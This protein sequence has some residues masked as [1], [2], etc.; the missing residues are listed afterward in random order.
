MGKLRVALV[1]DLIASYG[2]SEQVLFELH[3]MFPEARVYTSILDLSRLPPRFAELQVQTS[4]LQ[5]VPLL[6]RYYAAIVPFMPMAFESFDLR[7]FDLV[8]S[9]THAC[10]KGVRVPQGALHTCYCHTPIRYVWSHRQEYLDTLPLMPVTSPIARLALDRLRRWDFMAAQ[11]VDHFIANS[12]NVQARI[13]KYYNRQSEVVYPPVDLER[14]GRGGTEGIAEG[15]YLV[16]GRL[17][18]YKRIDVAVEAFTRLG[19]PLQVIGR[20]PELSRL[21]RI[22]GPTVTFLGEVD[23]RVLESAYRSCRA[24]IFTAD[25]DFGLVPLEAMASGRPVLALNA[26]GAPE[27]VITGVT[28]ELYE[29]SGVEALVGAIERFRPDDYDPS[30]CRRRAE[31]FS[32]D[33]FRCGIKTILERELGRPLV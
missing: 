19:L 27:T 33:R 8:L 21:R 15:A 25:E 6:H 17:F 4:F 11:R 7:D 9:S 1:H 24:L 30:A 3:R 2:G 18:S 10:S 12:K 22:A 13:D 14:F 23:D 31:E 29:D 16:V 26:G 28:G 32:V 5:N 20:G